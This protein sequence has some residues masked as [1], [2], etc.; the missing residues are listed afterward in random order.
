MKPHKQVEKLT[1]EDYDLVARVLSSP[2]AGDWPRA[3][4]EIA[5][6]R[7]KLAEHH[8][9]VA[10]AVQGEGRRGASGPEKRAVISR[11]YYAM[12]CAARAAL[13]LEGKG[14]VNDHQ[15]VPAILNKTTSLG[16]QDDREAVVADLNKYRALRNEADYSPYYPAPVGRDARAAVA[17]ARRVLRVCKRWV[18][19]IKKTRG[20]S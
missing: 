15:K 1:A 5:D 20:I 12:F 13:G 14:D 11:A 3:W 8:L 16:P 18:K 4:A 9:A 2:L 19:T 17:A 10:T 7:V 6:D